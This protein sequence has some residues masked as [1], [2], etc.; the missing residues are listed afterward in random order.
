MKNIL[1]LLFLLPILLFGQKYHTGTLVFKNGK[2]L[3]CM[4]RPPSRPDDNRIETKTSESAD[5]VIYKSEELKSLTIATEDSTVYE[6][7]NEKFKKMFG[8]LDDAWL[9]VMLKGYATLYG[10]SDGFKINKKG[11]LVL[12]STSYGPSTPDF[13]FYARRPGEDYITM[14]GLYSPATLGLNNFMRKACSKYF[15]DSPELVKKINDKK[16]KLED[17]TILVSEY[18]ALKEKSGGK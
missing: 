4:L 12:T 10:G 8:G 1:F 16:F 18:N 6:F 2:T 15:S 11:G 9:V 5:K 14:I 17:I 13:G 7:V 3:K